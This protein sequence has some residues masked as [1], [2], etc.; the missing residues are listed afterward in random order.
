MGMMTPLGSERFAQG[1]YS[2]SVPRLY[3]SHRVSFGASTPQELSGQLNAYLNGIEGYSGAQGY[4]APDRTPKLAFIFP[5]QGGQKVGMARELLVRE[6]VF[7]NTVELCDEVV[8]AEAGWS[9]LGLLQ[10]E[11]PDAL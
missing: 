10:G 5:G 6:P 4:I 7:R 8:R 3:Y 11:A 1:C 9:V 2:A